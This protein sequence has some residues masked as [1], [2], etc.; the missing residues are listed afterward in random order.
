MRCSGSSRF[1]NCLAMPS[2]RRRPAVAPPPLHDDALKTPAE[3]ELEAYLFGTGGGVDTC[4]S[5]ETVSLVVC[6][7]GGGVRTV[8]DT[9]H[10]ILV[11]FSTGT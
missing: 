5:G 7:G 3:L 9:R 10:G 2:K 8:V 4:V 6:G 11:I 1:L